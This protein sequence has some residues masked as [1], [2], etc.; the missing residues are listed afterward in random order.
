MIGKTPLV[1]PLLLLLLATAHGQGRIAQGPFVGH[2]TPD[3]VAI[4]ARLSAPGEYS[5]ALTDG[6]GSN[7]LTA[8]QTADPDRDLC[9]VWKIGGLQAN[10]QPVYD[11]IASGDPKAAA[12]AMTTHFRD[13]REK[14]EE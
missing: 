10:H 1:V 9:V 8:L 11:A 5:L 7:P 14:L 12:N 6:S 4:W 13:L 3:S 2:M